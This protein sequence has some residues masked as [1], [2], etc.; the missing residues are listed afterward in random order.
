MPENAA[1]AQGMAWMLHL[2]W[3]PGPLVQD[4]SQLPEACVQLPRVRVQWEPRLQPWRSTK[5]PGGAGEERVAPHASAHT[6]VG[7]GKA[8][9][10][11]TRQGVTVQPLGELGFLLWVDSKAL[12]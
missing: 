7:E 12:P 10:D 5:E 4:R 3:A 1:E 9:K 6:A 2:E 8:G 11:A